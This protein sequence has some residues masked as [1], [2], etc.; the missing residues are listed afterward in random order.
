M[1]ARMIMMQSVCGQRPQGRGHTQPHALT[2]LDLPLSGLGLTL[3]CSSSVTFTLP[4][5]ISWVGT[6]VCRLWK[7]HRFQ[8][9]L[10]HFKCH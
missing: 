1:N 2:W 8:T 9:G 6:Q 4:V 3:L 5:L 10:L 7:S